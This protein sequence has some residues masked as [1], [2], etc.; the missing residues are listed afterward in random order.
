MSKTEQTTAA[1]LTEDELY[2]QATAGIFHV[3]EGADVTS[4]GD[5]IVKW[6]NAR[7]G[8]HYYLLDAPT[9][10]QTL[11]KYESEF[12]SKNW[13]IAKTVGQGNVH[14]PSEGPNSV[15]LCISDADYDR[16]VWAPRLAKNK[17]HNKVFGIEAPGVESKRSETTIH[18]GGSVNNSLTM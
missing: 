18:S 13:C 16:Y 17:Y 4:S 10:E 2:K 12:R 8:Y 14:M 15:V 9:K 5:S 6:A 1:V 11:S 3:D 7:P